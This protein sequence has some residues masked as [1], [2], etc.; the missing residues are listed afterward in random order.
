[1]YVW[2]TEHSLSAFY[3][4]GVGLSILKLQITTWKGLMQTTVDADF[5]AFGIFIR[6]YPRHFS[7]LFI[8]GDGDSGSKR[9]VKTNGSGGR[10]SDRELFPLSSL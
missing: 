5:P 3:K 9:K 1:M 8:H 4:T 2:I 6:Q 10:I 7:P